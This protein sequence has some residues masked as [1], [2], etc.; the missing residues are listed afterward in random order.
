MK[1]SILE[2]KWLSIISR[3]LLIVL[4]VIMAEIIDKEVIFPTVRS[5][6]RSLID[7][8]NDSKFFIIMI[9]S[10]LRSLIG[11]LISLS[12]AIILGILSSISKVIYNLMK[13][14]LSFLSSVPT[15]AIIILALIW[16]NNDFVPMFVGF[17]MVFPILY[18]TVRGAIVNV[19]SNILE[20]ANIYNVNNFTIINNIY[21]PAIF[22]SL[23]QVFLSALN[24]TLKMI[25]A[26][27]ALSQPKYA[28]GSNLQLEKM[29]LNTSGVFAW[30][31][32]I[33]FISKFLE[34]LTKGLR[35]LY[36]TKKGK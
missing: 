14:I 1:G 20:M 28:I 17:L 19:D 29:Y 3:V 26:G 12:L 27:E 7:I 30:I 5:T 11:F 34:Y 4:W 10:L 35:N 24:T 32:I 25:I 2:D 23:D 22:L 21:I 18:E 13:P 8:I 9:H 15:M 16:F 33:L 6:L 36:N 31:I